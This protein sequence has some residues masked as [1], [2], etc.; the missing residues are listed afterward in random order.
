MASGIAHDFNNILAPILGFSEL[1]LVRPETLDNKEK[2]KSYLQMINTAA[3]DSARVVGRLREFYRYREQ[4]E[5]NLPL[6]LGDLVQ[7]VILLTQPKWKD[8]AQAAGKIINILTD[9]KSVPTVSANESEIREMLTNLLFNAID[10][11]VEKGGGTITFRIAQKGDDVSLQIADTG[12]GM[13]EDVRLK[14]IEPFFSTKHEHG[15]GLGLGIVHGIVRRHSGSIDI[16]SEEGEGTTVTVSLPVHSDKVT[17]EHSVPPPAENQKLRILVVEDEPLVR[18]VI[19]A[20]LTN[21]K[22]QIDTAVNGVD[23]LEKFRG[24]TYDIVMTDRAMPQMNGD[25][26]AKEIRKINPEQKVILITGFGDLISGTGEKPENIDLV[27]SK[28]FTMNHIREAV[29][30]LNK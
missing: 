1:L 21:D 18:E 24:S 17:P 10:A 9:F 16:A 13:S 27:V 22:H 3:K 12:V 20:Y 5:S 29:A 15:T 4:T 8:E 11:V 6:V 19:T 25:Q 14:C 7:Q 30:M 28:P 23:G 2:T 26:L